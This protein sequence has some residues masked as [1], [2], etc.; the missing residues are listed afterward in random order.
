MDPYRSGQY[1]WKNRSYTQPM[2]SPLTITLKLGQQKQFP[3]AQTDIKI[4]NSLIIVEQI[5]CE[6]IL[7]RT[8]LE[9]LFLLGI[10]Q[11]EGLSLLGYEEDSANADHWTN[12]C[13]TKRVETIHYH[14][15]LFKG[16]L[17]GPQVENGLFISSHYGE[18]ASL[19]KL[20]NLM[21]VI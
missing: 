14:W 10:T 19:G 9:I 13:R 7:D 4:P 12:D 6:G 2:F 8:F 15:E 20:E 21:L 5:I 1:Q 17:A 11:P 3:N 18:Y 16:S